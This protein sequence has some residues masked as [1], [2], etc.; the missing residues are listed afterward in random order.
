MKCDFS[1]AYYKYALKLA[2]EKKYEFLF[3]DEILENNKKRA[4]LLRHDIDISVQCALDMAQIEA[5]L[6]IRSTYFFRLNS[7]FYSPFSQQDYPKINQIIEMGHDLG[8]HFDPKFYSDNKLDVATS[9]KNERQALEDAFGVRVLA[10][11]QHRPFTLG[12]IET[13]SH[14]DLLKFLVQ[15]KF[16]M[17]RLK[18][19]SDS[20]Q[21]WRE[22]SISNHLEH[23]EQLQITVHP[24]WW[25]TEYLSWQDCIR[26][27]V[28][29]VTNHANS[30]MEQLIIRYDEYLS[31]RE[32]SN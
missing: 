10:L 21:R 5:D 22:G 19:I 7:T 25:K 30:K 24:I 31:N 12:M 29:D 14:P 28:A 6:G 27:S 15:N 13:Q 9:I 8:L 16:Y 11:A 2:L 20:G 4:I 1:Y 17:D 32:D 3:A 18:Y 26:T 23:H